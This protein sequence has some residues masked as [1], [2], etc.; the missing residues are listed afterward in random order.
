[1]A[2]ADKTIRKVDKMTSNIIDI[3]TINKNKAL[4]LLKDI[5]DEL[6]SKSDRLKIYQVELM[7]EQLIELDKGIL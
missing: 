4:Y 1:M 2:N 7:I 5:D 3:K 6:L